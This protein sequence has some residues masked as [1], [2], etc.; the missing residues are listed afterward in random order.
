[1][2]IVSLNIEESR[3]KYQAELNQ[4]IAQL[5]QLDQQRAVLIQ[6]IQERRGILAFLESLNTHKER[7][8]G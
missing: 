2:S 7:L 8:D 4:F 6:A 5:N 3:Q 1:M